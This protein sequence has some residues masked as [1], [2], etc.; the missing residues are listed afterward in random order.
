MRSFLRKDLL[1]YWRDRK[2]VLISL[3]APIVLIIILNFAFSGMFGEG[4][5]DLDMNVGIVLEDDEALGL[6][7]FEQRISEM[8]L[9]EKEFLI[10]QAALLS[11]VGLIEGLFNNPELSEW[12]TTEQL[13]EKDAKKRVANGELDALIKVPAKFTHDVLSQVLLSEPAETALILQVEEHSTESNVLQNIIDNYMDTLN[14]QFALNSV[15]DGEV[16]EPILPQGGSEV[17]EGVE[18]YNITQY[19]TIAMS[20]L[21][22]LFLASAVAMKTTTEKRERVFNRI[23]L[24]NHNPFSYLLGKT[25]SAF[26]LAWLQLVIVFTVSQLLLDVFPEKSLA[27]WLGI[28]L[29]ISFFSLTIA[30]LSALFTTLVLNMNNSEAASGLFNIIIMSLAAVGGNFFPIQAFPDW[31]QKIGGWTPN[32]LS[33]SVIMEWAQFGDPVAL[34]MPMIKLFCFFIGCLIIGMFLFPRRGRA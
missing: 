11:P 9:P 10:E 16:L 20:S 5:V 30:G 25:I 1:I 19:F 7:Q 6:Q 32:G 14:F 13:S 27:F 23:L 12:I 31:L 24:T 18:E 15:T 2:E 8:D 29:I 33:L 4:A 34:V 17:V 21:F 22:A 3:L 26:C 28:L